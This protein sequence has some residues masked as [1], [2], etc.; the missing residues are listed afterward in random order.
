MISQ[1]FPETYRFPQAFESFSSGSSERSGE[2]AAHGVQAAVLSRSPQQQ[3]MQQESSAARAVP[4]HEVFVP[5]SSLV[6]RT[7]REA[8]SAT[9]SS[10]AYW[11]CKLWQSFSTVDYKFEVLVDPGYRGVSPVDPNWDGVNCFDYRDEPHLTSED[12]NIEDTAPCPLRS[13]AE[14][15]QQVIELR[16]DIGLPP[17]TLPPQPPSL[18]RSESLESSRP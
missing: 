2:Q 17:T 7:V 1:S 14:E 3:M 5:S 4:D 10:S 16:K 9:T 11:P 13:S 15:L 18:D 12:G 6:E 8:E